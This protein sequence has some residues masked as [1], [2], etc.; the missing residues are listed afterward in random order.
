MRG[1]WIVLCVIGAVIFTVLAGVVAFA[2][3]EAR[4]EP[5]RIPNRVFWT[6]A[7]GAA[8]VACVTGIFRSRA[9]IERD[10]QSEPGP[11]ADWVKDMR[12]AQDEGGKPE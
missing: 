12:R 3:Y 8:A 2:A 4:N 10:M 9:E 1:A 6:F 11:V 5:A 7:F